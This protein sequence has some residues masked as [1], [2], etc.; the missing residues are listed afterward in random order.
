M[1]DAANHLI[2]QEQLEEFEYG[3]RETRA[4]NT[5]NVIEAEEVTNLP[6][7]REEGQV[8]KEQT[9]PLAV[10]THAFIDDPYFGAAEIELTPEQI[11]TLE[12]YRRVAHDKISIKPD[13]GLIYMDHM[14]YREVLNEAFGPGKW[15]L[16]PA[17]DFKVEDDGK[18]VTLYRS[19]RMYINGRFLREAVGAG[20]YFKANKKMNYADAAE[21]CESDVLKRMLKPFG[22]AG[23]C[24]DRRYQEWF[25]E[26]YCKRVKNSKGEMEWKRVKWDEAGW[27]DGKTKE[28]PE[29]ETTETTVEKQTTTVATKPT[30][31]GLI[32]ETGTL[33][34]KTKGTFYY[35]I[36][37]DVKYWTESKLVYKA[38]KQYQHDKYNVKFAYDDTGKNPAI[39]A[40]DL[41]E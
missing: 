13:D 38:A 20:A 15:A 24:W 36:V 34:T 28:L 6:A 7:V 25:K 18:V 21:T 37:D 19:Y 32:T 17:G 8:T 2:E 16:V 4:M 3:K 31:H 11:A 41:T 30:T 9:S 39:T 1:G 27:W 35:L 5:Q 14:G 40:W 33:E 22:I 12:K 23:Q 10:V 29:A 26:M